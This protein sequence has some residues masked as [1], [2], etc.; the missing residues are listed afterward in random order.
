M[1]LTASWLWSRVEG[2][3]GV[4]SR[5]SRSALQ[6]L[7]DPPPSIEDS[8]ALADVTEPPFASRPG[9]RREGN[10]EPE[11]ERRIVVDA[12]GI[13]PERR[14]HRVTSISGSRGRVYRGRV[15]LRAVDGQLSVSCRSAVGQMT[16]DEGKRSGNGCP[17][18]F[19]SFGRSLFQYHRCALPPPPGRSGR[20]RSPCRT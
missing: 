14:D 9:D 2:S 3:L 16:R 1:R 7:V 6:P 19:S 18:N 20:G 11:N 12:P 4:L 5:C 17:A 13:N 8:P 10:V 15:R